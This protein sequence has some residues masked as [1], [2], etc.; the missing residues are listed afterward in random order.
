MS[1]WD[2]RRAAIDGMEVDGVFSDLRNHFQAMVDVKDERHDDPDFFC[3]VCRH[4]LAGFDDTW[5]CFASEGELTEAQL[6][7]WVKYGDWD[8]GT[9]E[10][11]KRDRL[12]SADHADRQAMR[13]KAAGL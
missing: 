4:R 12:I 11:Y 5:I 7:S 8:P 10:V 2:V 13:R 6:D 9:S 1:D 3:Y